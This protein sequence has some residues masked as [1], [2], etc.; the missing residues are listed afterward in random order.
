[1]ERQVVG[2]GKL[3]FTLRDVITILVLVVSVAI[4]WGSMSVKTETMQ[5]NIEIN[6]DNINEYYKALDEFILEKANDRFVSK[7]LFEMWAKQI[8]EDIKEIKEMLKK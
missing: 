6:R 5:T 2:N 8:D 3:N 1:M 4:A 7:D